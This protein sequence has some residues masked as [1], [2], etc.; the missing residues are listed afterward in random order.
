MSRVEDFL[1]PKEEQEIINA[2]RIAEK[3]TSGEIR[4]HIETYLGVATLER[5]KE[6][7]CFLKM[8]ETAL[9][10]GVLFYVAVDSKQFAVIGGK[11]IDKNVPSDFWNSIKENVIYQFS[12][13]S[14]KTGLIVGITNAGEKLETYFPYK[15]TDTNELSDAISKG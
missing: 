1:T 8:N 5:A 3:K 14:Y 15:L 6:V 2:I 12:K 9:Q 13:G 4:V 10:N 7:F 11:D